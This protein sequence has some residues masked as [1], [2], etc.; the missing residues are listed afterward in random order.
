MNNRN[1]LL[2]IF[3]GIILAFVLNAVGIGVLFLL[4]VSIS[5]INALIGQ[6]CLFAIAGIGIFQVVYIIPYSVKL[7]RDGNIGMMKGLIIGAVI[8]ALLNGACWLS[9]SSLYG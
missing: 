8:V 1:E 6:L 4:G 3:L 7:K 5:Q 2:G 9:F